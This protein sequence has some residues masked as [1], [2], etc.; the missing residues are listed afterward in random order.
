MKVSLS[1][2]LPVCLSVSLSL[3]LSLSLSHTHTHTASEAE[4]VCADDAPVRCR[5]VLSVLSFLVLSVWARYFCYRTYQF[6]AEMV[7]MKQPFRAD[8][9][10]HK[11]VKLLS[12][13][14]SQNNQSTILWVC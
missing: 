2:C 11:I 6:R 10:A 3:S 8:E 12:T 7:P 13:F 4:L 14:T 5:V 1:V 9:A